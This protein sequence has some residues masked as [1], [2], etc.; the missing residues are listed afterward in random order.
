VNSGNV[1]NQSKDRYEWNTIPWRKLEVIVFKLQKRI[2]RA[3]Q[4]GDVRL[5][6]RLQRLLLKSRSA[7]MLAVRRVTQ[8]N[9]GRKTAGIDGVAQ[10][11]PAE[12][13]RLVEMLNLNEKSMPLRRAWIAKPGKV[14][15]RPLG[16]PTMADRAKQA[17]VKMVLEPE[18]EAKFEPNSYGFRPGRSCHDARGAIFISLIGKT[19]YILDADITGC[20]DHINHCALLEKLNTIPLLRKI[21]KGVTSRGDGNWSFLRHRAGPQGTVVESSQIALG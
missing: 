4:R 19:A 12:R 13:L 16:I 6:H 14:E 9:Q 18:W 2:Y 20:F 5:V 10:L 21:V 3:S 17:L 11:T 15:K 7:K 8:D 1:M